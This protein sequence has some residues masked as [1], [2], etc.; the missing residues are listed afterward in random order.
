MREG[1]RGCFLSA[2][3]GMQQASVAQRDRAKVERKTDTA[4]KDF[5]ICV[6]WK[7]SEKSQQFC[8]QKIKTGSTLIAERPISIPSPGN[9]CEEIKLDEFEALKKP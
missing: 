6:C 7:E 2:Q 4:V 8:F 5:L 9:P 1:E 3:E